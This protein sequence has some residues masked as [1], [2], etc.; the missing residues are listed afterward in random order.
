MVSTKRLI[1]DAKTGR[2][3]Y[4]DAEIELSQVASVLEGRD[5]IKEFD[6]LVALLKSKKII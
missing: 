2:T 6:D 4:V 1:I 3:E 5:I